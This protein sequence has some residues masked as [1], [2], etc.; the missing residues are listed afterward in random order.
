MNAGQ[1][2]SPVL[3][4]VGTVL[5][6]AG[7]LADRGRYKAWLVLKSFL[8]PG[9]PGLASLYLGIAFLAIAGA[10]FV[11]EH[12]PPLVFLLFALVLFASMVLGIVGMFWLPSLML[13]AWVKETR[14]RL[15][16]GEDRLSRAL[17]PGGALHGRLGVDAPGDD[18]A[19]AGTG[20]PGPGGT[21]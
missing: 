19:G 11:M 9:W 20:R 17:R 12:A 5:V 2:M 6:V 15:A 18:D 13:P 10:G 4:A 7:V 14:R 1:L 21:P 8:F 3:A 16:A